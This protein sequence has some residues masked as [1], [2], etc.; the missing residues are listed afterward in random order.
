MWQMYDRKKL[1]RLITYYMSKGRLKSIHK[2][3]YAYDN[4]Y[5]SLDV[6]QKLIPLS[7]IS[8]Y[9]TSQMHGLTFQYYSSIYC[10]SLK[11]RSYKLGNQGYFYHKVKETIF[12][13]P[14][15]LINN[16]RYIF[17]D[18]ERTIC[19]MLYVF[20]SIGFDNLHRLILTN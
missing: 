3:V 1:V 4:N 14:S 7:Y 9:T 10:I 2:G 11:S 15:G 19:D 17:A 5:E 20:P 12:Y 8:L 18:R 6:A 16:G 13:N